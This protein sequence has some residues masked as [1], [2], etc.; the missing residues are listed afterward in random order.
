MVLNIGIVGACVG[1]LSAA[2][3]LRQRGHSVHIFGRTLELAEVGAAFSLWPNALAALDCLDLGTSVRDRWQREEDGALR[4]QSG[5]S[6]WTFDK[7]TSL[8]FV[9]PFN[10]YFSAERAMSRCRPV[11]GVRGYLALDKADDPARRRVCSR[12]RSGGRCRRDS[13]SVRSSIAQG[14]RPPFYSGGTA[15]PRG[16]RSVSAITVTI[17]WIPRR[18]W[19]VARPQAYGL[20][21]RA[22]G[23]LALDRVLRDDPVREGADDGRG[24]V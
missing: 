24:A 19:V 20:E 15:W 5:A 2:I 1:G 11:R 4:K 22:M 10:R 13:S 16:T 23:G 6:F 21:S 7:A 3:A 14:E 9:Q 17:G 18:G 8:S 12:V